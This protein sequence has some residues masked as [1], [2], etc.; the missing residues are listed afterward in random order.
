MEKQINIITKKINSQLEIIIDNTSDCFKTLILKQHFEKE[1]IPIEVRVEIDVL[2]KQ[3][4]INGVGLNKTEI[5]I[6][7][8]FISQIKL[9]TL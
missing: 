4:E 7:Q 9:N 1:S 5:A 2:N 3:M 8:E 6:F